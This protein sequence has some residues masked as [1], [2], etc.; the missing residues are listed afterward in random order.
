VV[1]AKTVYDNR[2]GIAKVAGTTA[3]LTGKAVLGTAKLT[4]KAVVAAVENPRKSAV[5][6]AAA[7]AI[8]SRSWRLRWCR[9]RCSN[10]KRQELSI[11]MSGH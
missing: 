5:M 1:V 8:V 3:L 2:E 11:I 9:S 10:S 4:G 7:A 6:A